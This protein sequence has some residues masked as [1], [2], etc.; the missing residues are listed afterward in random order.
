MYKIYVVGKQV[1]VECSDTRAKE[2]IAKWK[3]NPASHEIADTDIGICSFKIKDIKSFECEN[4]EDESRS[5]VDPSADFFKQ[6]LQNARQGS[7]AKIKQNKVVFKIF[8]KFVTGNEPTEEDYKKYY[9]GQARKYFEDNAYATIMDTAI[10]RD[11]LKDL[12]ASYRKEPEYS[13]QFKMLHAIVNA[14]IK[15]HAWDKEYMNNRM[16]YEEAYGN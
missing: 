11:T 5:W 14:I 16:K 6:W 3:E 15:T 1:P 7:E 9:Y 12:A 13:L 2:L 4:P 10:M 8:F